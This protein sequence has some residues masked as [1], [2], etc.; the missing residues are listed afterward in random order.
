MGRALT[1]RYNAA[2]TPTFIVFGLDG[3]ERY[4]ATGLPDIKRIK[5]E[6]PSAVLS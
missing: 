1:A 5:A 6:A 2:Y 3:D 4:R